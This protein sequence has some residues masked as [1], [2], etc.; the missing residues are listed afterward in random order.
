[1]NVRTRLLAAG[2]GTVTV[3]AT[4]V[5]IGWL[6]VRQRVIP[7]LESARER[8][9]MST[10][11]A[12]T[13][14]LVEPLAQEDAAAARAVL[15]P[16]ADDP[17]L[18]TAVVLDAQGQVLARVGT[19]G[20]GEQVE[21]AAVEVEG[22][23]LGAVEIGYDD[24][25]VREVNGW[26]RV[27]GGATLLVVLLVTALGVWFAR[28]VTTPIHRMMEFARQVAAG[29][30]DQ[31]LPEA[32]RD[33]LGELARHLNHMT[34]SIHDRENKLGAARAELM[35]S[36]RLASVGEMAG[37]T[38]HEVLN[39][40]TSVRGRLDKMSGR[41][42]AEP[43]DDYL[44]LMNEIVGGWRE[45]YAA[46]GPRELMAQL[47]QPVEGEAGTLLEED[48]DNLVAV[49]GAIRS[50]HDE[51]KLDV[52]FMRR[53]I[54]RVV[55]IVDGMRSLSRSFG[56]ATAES[57]AGLLGEAAEI[58]S[59]S[60]HKRHIRLEVVA[61]PHAAIVVDR[62]EMMQVLTNLLRNAM[63]AVEE[64]RGRDGG[65][66]RLELETLGGRAL[67]RVTDNGCGIPAANQPY[68]FESSFTTRAA[69]DGTGLGLSIAR[70]LVRSAGGELSL[71]SS[72]PGA[73]TTFLIDL[74]LAQPGEIHATNSAAA[75]A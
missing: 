31:R 32:R 54:D 36:T 18:V 58:V 26:L 47:Q 15:A 2:L 19:A 40:V 37:R 17:A 25:H 75:T 39:P 16:L 52:E 23:A 12:L 50:L 27:V 9:A 74:P 60:V 3:F 61:A 35:R 72:G 21:R 53:E 11:Q 20:A 70:R 6:G 48:L 41:F 69:S 55:R 64:H 71:E 65:V 8:K 38:A 24:L 57:V 68:I 10:A 43:I 34:R 67:V 33:E 62:Y 49:T 42:G 66:I 30:R 46:G 56:T 44:E 51:R 5:A 1:M 13:I 73:G 22:L 45:A 59:D 14:E 7:E 63:L 29:E 4:L 28:S